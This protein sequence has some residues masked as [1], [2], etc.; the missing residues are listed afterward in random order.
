MEYPLTMNGKRDSFP[1]GVLIPVVMEYP[2]TDKDAANYIR[3]NL[4]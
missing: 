3:T 2:L 4:S 1:Y